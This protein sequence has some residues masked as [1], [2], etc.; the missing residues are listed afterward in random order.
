MGRTKRDRPL[1]GTVAIGVAVAVLCGIAR[2]SG[3]CVGTDCMNIWSTEPGGGALTMEWN[4]QRKVQT[5]RSLCA[6]GECLFSAIDPGFRAPGQDAA[7]ADLFSLAPATTI[8]LEL[9]DRDPAVTIRINGVPL[10][11][12]GES[13]LLG[14]APD[15]HSHP[16]WQL[17]APEGSAGDYQL[18]FRLE[19]D[20]A[21]Y[22]SSEVLVVIVTNVATPTVAAPSATPTPTP[23]P[24]TPATACVGDCDGDRVVSISELVGAVSHALDGGTPCAAV[25]TNRDGAVAIAE[26]VAA[27]GAALAGCP[28]PATPPPVP[29]IAFAAIRDAILVPRCAIPTCHDAAARSGNLALDAA[30]AYDALVGV[31]PNIDTAREAG[32][33]LV[34]PGEPDNSFLLI[35]L[36]GPP[37]D[38]GSRMPLT[39]TP[40]SESETAAIADWI[41]RGAER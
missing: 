17:S 4:P 15:I 20:S 27:V 25:D 2:P 33:L 1:A 35:K 31:E 5:F 21:S 36:S 30:S 6:G 16:S 23:T 39:G 11:Q 8:R 34:D 40:L 3:A 24:T 26:L 29:T 37:P 19:T 28:S 7:P 13:A 10:R 38:Q 22:R 9:V 41:A 14:T 32:L 12:P 18:A